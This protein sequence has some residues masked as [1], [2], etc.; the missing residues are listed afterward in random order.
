MAT[1]VEKTKKEWNNWITKI[2]CF[3]QHKKK[4]QGKNE[5]ELASKNFLNSFNPICYCFSF[6][7]NIVSFVFFFLFCLN[8]SK[9]QRNDTFTLQFHINFF[10]FFLSLLFILKKKTQKQQPKKL[11]SISSSF[12]P[13][14]FFSF[15]S[16]Y[17]PPLFN[18]SLLTKKF[19]TTTTKKKAPI[20]Q[21][22]ELIRKKTN[23]IAKAEQKIKKKKNRRKKSWFLFYAK[24]RRKIFTAF[25]MIKPKPLWSILS[26]FFFFLIFFS[27]LI[28]KL[29]EQCSLANSFDI[30]VWVCPS[31]IWDHHFLIPYLQYTISGLQNSQ[32]IA[33]LL[34]LLHWPNFVRSLY[35]FIKMIAKL[36]DLHKF[37]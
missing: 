24:W 15:I 10:F 37:G 21:R 3:G 22:E 32:L 28:A 34:F 25:S 13:F 8:V 19:K 17:L 6:F 26:S 18:H 2:F 7:S 31:N 35:S 30:V 12:F 16:I 11:S 33:V 5:A 20:Q 1:L 4:N 27:R 23:Y 29:Q 9:G 36:P 14:L